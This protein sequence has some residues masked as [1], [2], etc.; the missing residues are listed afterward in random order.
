M[1]EWTFS[2]SHKT[3]LSSSLLIKFHVM[4]SDKYGRHIMHFGSGTAVLW[5]HKKNYLLKKSSKKIKNSP[6]HQK[7]NHF[8]NWLSF[9]FTSKNSSIF[10]WQVYHDICNKG[11]AYYSLFDF[12]YVKSKEFSSVQTVTK[13]KKCIFFSSAKSVYFLNLILNLSKQKI[14]IKK[15]KWRFL[16]IDENL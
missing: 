12:S 8:K 7:K 15:K 1:A 10:Q 11:S 14:I 5:I 3:T 2:L 4:Y 6:P 9:Y 13:K 16:K